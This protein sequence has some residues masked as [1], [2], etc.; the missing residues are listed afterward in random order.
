MIR[1]SVSPVLALLALGCAA[2]WQPLETAAFQGAAP[3]TIVAGIPGNLP[4]GG[5][6]FD[7]QEPGEALARAIVLPAGVLAGAFDTRGRRLVEKHR[8]D[9]PARELAVRLTTA[10]GRKHALEIKP[11]KPLYSNRTTRDV[12]NA[13]LVLDV[14]TETWGIKPLNAVAK[15]M[16]VVYHALLELYDRRNKRIIA[17]GRCLAPELDKP[18]APTL[19]V[20]L[21]DDARFLK[22]DL[23]RITAYCLQGFAR[24][25]LGVWDDARGSLHGEAAASPAPPNDRQPQEPVRR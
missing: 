1:L 18:S 23:A 2:P 7:F 22:K 8:I 24:K 14:R 3:R 15:E 13:D 17:T 20:M 4:G 10:L 11:P 25:L 5:P 9:D 16:T 12:W 19:E 6:D 21:A